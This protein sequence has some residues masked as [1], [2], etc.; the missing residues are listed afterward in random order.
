M[1]LHSK[2][3][4]EFAW[5]LPEAPDGVGEVVMLITM[6]HARMA[7]GRWWFMPYQS[8]ST[9]EIALVYELKR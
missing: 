8:P 2:H 9:E 6:R 3:V 4:Y 5:L 7:S 1:K